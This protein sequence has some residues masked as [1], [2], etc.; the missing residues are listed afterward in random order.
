MSKDAVSQDK[1]MTEAIK[2]E[3]RFE[4]T[5]FKPFQQHKQT[6]AIPHNPASVDPAK[7]FAKVAAMVMA[8]GEDSLQQATEPAVKKEK[9]GYETS[10][11]AVGFVGV[12]FPFAL[13]ESWQLHH[14]C[15]QLKTLSTIFATESAGRRVWRQ[16]KSLESLESRFILPRCV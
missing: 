14:L 12:Q 7:H 11:N 4:Y 13:L 9:F 16:R 6:Q 5:G 10:S 8:E 3:E 2:K 15:N 1:L